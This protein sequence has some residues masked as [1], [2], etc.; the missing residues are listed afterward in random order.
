MKFELTTAYQ[1]AGGSAEPLIADG[2]T[3]TTET[4]VGKHGQVETYRTIEIDSMDDLATFCNV[5]RGGVI[6]YG[7]VII[8]FSHRNE[9]Q[10]PLLVI[11]DYFRG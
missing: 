10:L 3:V 11:Y 4:R 9:G 7:D 2:F 8:D 1:L 5:I 6:A